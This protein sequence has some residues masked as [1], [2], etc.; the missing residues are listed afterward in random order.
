MFS[1]MTI[2]SG[3][4]MGEI[5]DGKQ[6]HFFDYS[7][8]TNFLN[9]FMETLLCAHG[10]WEPYTYKNQFRTELEP[11]VED[12]Y[13]SREQDRLVINIKNYESRYS[14][15]VK[16][17]IRLTFNFYE[18]LAE[19]LQEMERVLRFYGLVGYRENWNFEFPVALYL[20]LKN[21]CKGQ[22]RLDISEIAADQHLGMDA[23]VSDL[24]KELELLREAWED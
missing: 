8:I 20:M 21:I 9:D 18:F 24:D 23:K 1:I 6:Q 19:F 2:S 7:Y 5:G 16:K 3:W 15:K 4:I 11:A 12:W 13:I 14:D 10:E 17:E 22:N